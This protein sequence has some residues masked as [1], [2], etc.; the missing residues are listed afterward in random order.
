M[1]TQFI[2]KTLLIL[3][4]LMAALTAGFSPKASAQTNDM[5][6]AN[7]VVIYN[8]DCDC[9]GYSN[10]SY[11]Y[12]DGWF[13]DPYFHEWYFDP[14]YDPYEGEWRYDPYVDS[15]FFIYFSWYDD[16]DHWD[17]VDTAIVVTAV[18][19]AASSDCSMSNRPAPSPALA[20]AALAAIGLAVLLRRRINN[21][22]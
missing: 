15:W 10:Y 19:V 1:N 5:S 22:Y 7:T 3:G 12:G 13:Y 18:A 2:Q 17:E 14:Y 6:E 4:I 11:Y 8:G 16:D 20:T 21:R 9:D